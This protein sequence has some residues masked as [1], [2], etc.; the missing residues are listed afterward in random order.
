MSKEIKYWLIIGV[1][2]LVLGI[3]FANREY[4]A[5]YDRGFNDGFNKCLSNIDT[6]TKYI[7][8]KTKI[9]TVWKRRKGITM[10]VP[11]IIE[12]KLVLDSTLAI[13]SLGKI[14]IFTSDSTGNRIFIKHD[15]KIP[16][17]NKERIDSVIKEIFIP[18]M[19]DPIIIDNAYW[20]G[21]WTAVIGAITIVG[22]VIIAILI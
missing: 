15:F 13:D 10:I 8:G 20:K 19:I 22:T 7:K 5:T 14:R 17:F 11:K 6:T 3:W 2:L 4:H 12:G 9:D 21:F 1:G 16:E 18:K